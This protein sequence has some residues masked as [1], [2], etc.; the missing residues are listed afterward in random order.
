MKNMVEIK[1][2]SSNPIDQ[3]LVDTTIAIH[4]AICEI[5]M[6]HVS[7]GVPGLRVIASLAAATGM[8]LGKFSLASEQSDEERQHLHSLIKTVEGNAFMVIRDKQN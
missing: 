8:I 1:G 7:Y 3:Q 6:Q 4:N 5:T 2:D